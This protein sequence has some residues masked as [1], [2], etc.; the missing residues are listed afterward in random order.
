M[1]SFNYMKTLFTKSEN[2]KPAYKDLIDPLTFI[3]VNKF[4]EDSAKEVAKGF[5]EAHNTGQPIVPIKID[6]YGGQV[7]SLLAMLAEIE[8]SKL[9]VATLVMGKAMSCGA[10][11]LGL[12]NIGH[13]YA[14]AN[15]TIMIHDVSKSS[16]GKIE[17]LK[18]DIK[19]VERLSTLIFQKLALHCGHK[20]KDY[21]LKL[22]ASKKHVDWYLTPAEAKKHKLID[23][24]GVPHFSVN[25]KTDIKFGL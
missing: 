13:R 18:A 25:I 21:F 19:E 23:H 3:Q 20:N 7:H 17:D 11:L 10:I 24:V 6:S 5:A 9:P 22:I 8:S 14:D 16:W 1:L 15:S 12:G 2:I 4:T